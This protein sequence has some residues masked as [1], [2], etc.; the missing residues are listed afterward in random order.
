MKF[1]ALLVLLGTLAFTSSLV[2]ETV[3]A[4]V[5]YKTKDANGQ[6]YPTEIYSVPMSSSKT[7]QCPSKP[8]DRP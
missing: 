6:P 2:A 4:T 1:I 3:I 5:E 7:F 8:M